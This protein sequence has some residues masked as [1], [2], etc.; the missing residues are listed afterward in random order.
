M[1][2][3]G[4]LWVVQRRMGLQWIVKSVK[5]MKRVDIKVFRYRFSKTLLMFFNRLRSDFILFRSP[6]KK[7]SPVIG[8]ELKCVK[9]Q[10]L[11]KSM[12]L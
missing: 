4:R 9:I 1:D 5:S 7:N 8:Y 2:P 6:K 12:L 11:V 3:D 10:F